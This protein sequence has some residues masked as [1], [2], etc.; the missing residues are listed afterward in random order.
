MPPESSVGGDEESTFTNTGSTLDERS[1]RKMRKAAN[2]LAKKIFSQSATRLKRID[3]SYSLRSD[4]A[5]ASYQVAPTLKHRDGT[6]TVNALSNFIRTD[7]RRNSPPSVEL[8]PRPAT[9]PPVA[10]VLSFRTPKPHSTRKA[11]RTIPGIDATPLTL[12]PGKTP[13]PDRQRMVPESGSGKRTRTRPP[14][15]RLVMPD[16]EHG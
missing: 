4:K 11:D 5:F 7:K 12:N 16:D 9:P 14:R 6:I 1:N 15:R 3:N 13:G 8:A 10:E 2:L